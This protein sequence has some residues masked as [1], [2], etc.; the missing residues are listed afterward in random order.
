M[1]SACGDWVA[2]LR[3]PYDGRFGTQ[4]IW[5][6]TTDQGAPV[7]VERG[8]QGM[9]NSLFRVQIAGEAYACKLFVA[10]GRQRDYREWAAIQ[11]LWRAELPLAPRPVAYFPGGPLPVP[12]VI[13]SWVDGVS[14]TREPL[15]AHALV[16]L[17]NALA[18][19]HRVPRAPTPEL[20]AAFHQ[21]PRFTD[22]LAEIRANTGQVQAWAEQAN[23]RPPMLA[24]WAAD[25]PELLPALV[26]ALH[27]AEAAISDARLDDICPADSLIR[28]DGNLDNVLRGA[29]GRLTFVDWEYSGLGDPAYELAELRWHPNAMRFPSAWWDTALATYPTPPGDDDFRHRLRLFNHLLP[30]WWVG[31]NALFLLEGAGQIAARPRLAPIPDGIYDQARRRTAALLALLGLDRTLEVA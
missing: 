21:P 23:T 10:D 25:L 7:R 18:H 9:N 28:V 1:V 22:Y 3:T 15:T 8:A 16:E 27:L 19:I 11:Q 6:L 5:E 4:T 24:Q 30:I 2:L 26:N 12:A 29:D 20:L 13:Y 17:V 31:R 14:L